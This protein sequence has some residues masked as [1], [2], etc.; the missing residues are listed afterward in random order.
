MRLRKVKILLKITELKIGDLAIEFRSNF[1][2]HP[3]TTMYSV[4]EMRTWYI[5]G[6]ESSV[7]R[8]GVRGMIDSG[9][10]ETKKK[11]YQNQK[12]INH[13]EEFAF[14]GKH[15]GGAAVKQIYFL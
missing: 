10:N 14:T 6:F 12:I 13:I 1:N 8:E 11:K 2:T 5:Q 7:Y 9:K 15:C 4:L 3:W